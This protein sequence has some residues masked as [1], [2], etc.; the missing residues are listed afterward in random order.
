MGC[1]CSHA[2]QPTAHHPHG[3]AFALPAQPVPWLP[4]EQGSRGTL[5][6][7]GGPAEV[8]GFRSTGRV[9]GVAP[10]PLLPVH[11]PERA[12]GRQ[13]A[14]GGT[15]PSW[16]LQQDTRQQQPGPESRREVLP[17][18]GVRTGARLG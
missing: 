14:C 11:T 8:M 4:L 6:G 13:A 2:A 18:T 5:V 17:K 16:L 9:L 12:E 7:V 3:S 1:C 15:V 10:S